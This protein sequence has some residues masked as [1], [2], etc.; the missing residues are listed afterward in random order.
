MSGTLPLS[1]VQRVNC[2]QHD[3]HW[4]TIMMTVLTT[5]ADH[6]C[7]LHRYRIYFILSEDNQSLLV[8]WQ[9]P[10]FEDMICNRM[11]QTTLHNRVP[12]E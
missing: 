7:N 11:T 4:Q 1:P 6:W 10:P 2:F 9:L 8:C 12:A 3:L 5:S